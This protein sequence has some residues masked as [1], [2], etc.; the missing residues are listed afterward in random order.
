M[1]TLSRLRLFG[2]VVFASPAALLTG[3]TGESAGTG[4]LEQPSSGALRGEL[5]S[6]VATRDDGTSD[7]YYVLRRGDDEV[8]LIFDGD[9]DLVSGETV[10]VWASREGDR[11]RVRR[12][13]VVQPIAQPLVNAPAYAP[14]SF[15]MAI[16]HVGGVPTNPLSLETA[17]TK[18][19]GLTAGTQPSIRQYYVEAS[20][21]RQDIAGDVAG[22]FD[23]P[24][25]TCNTSAMA[26]ALRPM[27]PGTYNHYLWYMEPRIASCG[28]SGLASGGSPTR[29]ARDTW[30]NASSGCVVLMQEP[31][32]NFG[33]RH[34][35]FMKC[36]GVPFVDAPDGTCMHNEY[37]DRYD[38]MG[39]AAGT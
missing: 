31:G 26:T 11:L 4:T 2:I 32:H 29:P 3:C 15:V 38:P 27:I 33:M 9:P 34:S 35:S 20:Y 24:T 19:F 7:E 14:R 13:E 23:F 12:F 30:Y 6:Y 39:A 18:L 10:D 5:V 16:V 22:P 28:F 36:P 17:R 21:G 1:P 37:G 8:R 25:T